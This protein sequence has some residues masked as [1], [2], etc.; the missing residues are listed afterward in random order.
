MSKHDNAEEEV[1][2]CT[3]VEVSLAETDLYDSVQWC[4]R[5]Y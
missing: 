4:S 5:H 2:I 1:I 3:N